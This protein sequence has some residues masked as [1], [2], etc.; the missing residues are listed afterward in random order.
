MIAEVDAARVAYLQAALD[1]LPPGDTGL[2]ARVMARLAAAMQPAD[3]P[4]GPI[5]LARRAVQ[6]A[7]RLGDETTLLATVRSATSALMDFA[8][9]SERKELNEEHIRLAEALHEPVE[10]LRGMTRL[11][12]DLVQVGDLASARSTVDAAARTADRLQHPYYRWRPAL[13]QAMMAQAAGDFGAWDERID[14]ARRL[15]KACNDPN[16]PRTLFLHELDVLVQRGRYEAAHALLPELAAFLGGSLLWE[17]VS[18][19]T[20]RALKLC[21]HRAVEGAS[22]S[23]DRG[24]R[25]IAR[26]GD[27]A[28]LRDAARACVALG[29]REYAAMLYEGFVDAPYAFMHGGMFEVSIK[30]PI[31]LTLGALARLLGRAE[32]AKRHFSE[33]LDVAT[34][35]GT[36]P[37]AAWAELELSVS[38]IAD[39]GF[40]EAKERLDRAASVA[41][42]LDLP[43][44]LARVSAARETLP[45]PG[46]AAVSAST[47]PVRLPTAGRPGPESGFSLE[48][49][50]DMWRLTCGD[51]TFLVRDTR[52][53]HMLHRLITE[54]GREFHA[55]DLVSWGGRG[56]DLGDAGE[57]LDP[58]AR[59]EYERRI[60]DLRAELEEAEAFGDLG[61]TT[62]AREELDFLAGELGRAVG[63]GGRERRVGSNTERARVNAQRRLRDAIRRIGEH[64]RDLAKHLEW[65]VKTGTFCSY[66]PE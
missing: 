21:S 46:P 51:T 50:G 12:F 9:P 27:S 15:V 45:A 41:E 30:G 6:M 23:I 64:H 47:P 56:Q 10:A 32:D 18:G 66:S 29:E 26:S 58:R 34:R 7:R 16:G 33:A 40:E 39:G 44:L 17:L 49:E 63:I 22:D 19:S 37:F 42:Q 55:L 65:A 54:P 59:A 20:V 36:V 4:S 24:M 53:M 28:L 3:D 2:R 61:R 35:A 48:R 43:D 13:L 52:G 14:E 62:R 38:L 25:R 8:H 31:G 1:G 11:V 57:I 5:E 60:A